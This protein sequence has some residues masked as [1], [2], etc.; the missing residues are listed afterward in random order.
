MFRF[1]LDRQGPR[2]PSLH[3]RP[4]QGLARFTAGP[5]TEEAQQVWLSP[6]RAEPAA[7]HRGPEGLPG[8]PERP[9]LHPGSELMSQKNDFLVRTGETAHD[10]WA[11]GNT[12]ERAGWRFAGIR[13]VELAAGASQ[14][15]R[16]GQDEALVLPLG[17]SC[18]VTVAGATCELAGRPDVFTAVTDSLCRPRESTANITS[19][20]GGRFAIATGRATRALEA[21]YRPASDVLVGLRGAGS[22]SRQVKNLYYLNVMAGPAADGTWL[23]TDDPAHHWVRRT[24]DSQDVAPRLPMTRPVNTTQDV[25]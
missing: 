12:P 13:I 15:L 25:Q 2:L 16:T 21:Y 7:L 1:A 20:Q 19:T 22:R 10:Q 18:S 9:G 14:E 24:W 17:G 3:A 6:P 11:R 5:R 8:G 23:M 4:H